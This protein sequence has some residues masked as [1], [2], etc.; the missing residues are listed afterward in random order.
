M[1]GVAGL[2]YHSPGYRLDSSP[3]DVGDC[4]MSVLLGGV[5]AEKRCSLSNRG[6]GEVDRVLRLSPGADFV[7]RELSCVCGECPI[8]TRLVWR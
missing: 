6:G 2:L 1:R 4:V 5:G 7:V 3:Q 8:M